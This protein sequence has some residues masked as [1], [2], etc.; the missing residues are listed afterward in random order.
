VPV[1]SE[2][3]TFPTSYESAIEVKMLHSQET[4]TVYEWIDMENSRWRL[5]DS[6]S[7]TMIMMDMNKNV[8]YQ[9]HIETD[10][11]TVSIPLHDRQY[12]PHYASPQMLIA[13]GIEKALVG[14][15]TI[16]GIPC[17]H[18][19]GKHDGMN[20]TIHFYISEPGW[21]WEFDGEKF[22]GDYP[23]RI[24]AEGTVN[25]Q[26][27]HMM[28][29]FVHFVPK[30]PS[31]H[32][33]RIPHHWR[34]PSLYPITLPNLPTAFESAMEFTTPSRM[35]TGNMYEIYDTDT[36]NAMFWYEW[37][38]AKVHRIYKLGQTPPVAYEIINDTT[39]T[40]WD[41]TDDAANEQHKAF[42]YVSVKQGSLQT[43][44]SH[45]LFETSDVDEQYYG[46]ATVRGIT[47]DHWWADVTHRYLADRPD[48][49]NRTKLY[50]SW[51]F[52]AQEW[53][54][55]S[56]LLHNHRVPV[57][58]N[59]SG[60]I[61]DD[62]DDDE[63]ETEEP[64]TEDPEEED[65]D[66]GEFFTMSV[67]YFRFIPADTNAHRFETLPEQCQASISGSNV[68]PNQP[69]DNNSSSSGQVSAATAIVLAV[70]GLVLGVLAGMAVF[71]F[72]AKSRVQ[73]PAPVQEEMNHM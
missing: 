6:I 69:E 2:F 64:G 8:V 27:F 26:L 67:D 17:Y 68:G 5:H 15:E 16:R 18:Y 61:F 21:V 52:S 72:L 13:S 58:V 10:N 30:S 47:V 40:S 20:L 3:P 50:V 65:D 37:H 9:Y 43:I 4:F 63:A 70:V 57:R 7:D 1:P 14:Y 11:C 48:A 22:T 41:P 42:G 73:T 54:M 49:D 32:V 38:G 44:R 25:N 23:V 39:C 60:R 45:L 46:Q 36:N 31:D 53:D 19:S 56:S 29:D 51:Y 34:C 55:R 24:E 71:Y 33:W 66:D 35:Q 59:V 12:M 28:N 62:D